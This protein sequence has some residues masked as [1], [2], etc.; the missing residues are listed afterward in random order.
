MSQQDVDA[1]NRGFLLALAHLALDDGKVSRAEKAELLAMAQLLHVPTAAVTAVLDQAE[2]ARH[3]RLSAGLQPLP[4]TWEHGEPLRVGD[5]IAFTGWDEQLRERLEQRAEK[6]G[7]RVLN[8][9]S[10]R[11]A[12]LITDDSFHGGKAADAAALGTRHVTPQVFE[13]LLRHLQPAAPRRV[14]V[15]VQR[16]ECELARD[17]DTAPEVS[18]HTTGTVA[19]NVAPAVVRAWAARNGFT[20]GVRGRLPA[21]VL[22]AYRQAHATTLGTSPT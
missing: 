6:L 2:A 15:P 14:A 4:S 7:V 16:T 13:V 12:M 19:A 9:V 5:K 17:N 10:G 18:G 1:A 20:V 22:E 21:E 11:T 3:E 8:N